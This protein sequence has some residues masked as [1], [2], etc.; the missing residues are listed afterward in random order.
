MAKAIADNT[1]ACRVSG[2]LATLHRVLAEAGLLFDDLQTPIDD[3]R[4]R[5]RLVRFWQNGAIELTDSQRQARDIMGENFHCYRAWL[6]LGFYL[7]ASELMEKL[8]VIPFS[9]KVLEEAKDDYLLF[10]DPGAPIRLMYGGLEKLGIAAPCN[11]AWFFKRN[12]DFVNQR[13]NPRWRL[14]KK[15]PVADPYYGRDSSVI[16][17]KTGYR[18]PEARTLV[19]AVVA[20]YLDCQELLYPTETKSSSRIESGNGCPIVGVSTG[21]GKI[22][23]AAYDTCPCDLMSF[24]LEIKPDLAGKCNP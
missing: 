20:Q 13:R 2:R 15:A 23:L 4:M 17:P 1:E 7:L 22:I 8:S 19:M 6:T 24:G 14:V 18:W 9:A 16:F 11:E 5:Q 10:P 12:C 21:S 3:R